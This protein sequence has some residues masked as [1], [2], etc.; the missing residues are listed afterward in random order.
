[1]H[2]IKNNARR[3]MQTKKHFKIIKLCKKQTTLSYKDDFS[4]LKNSGCMTIF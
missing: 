1:M 4:Y 2:S 3:T